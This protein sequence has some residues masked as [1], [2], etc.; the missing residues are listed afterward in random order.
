MTNLTE[1]QSFTGFAYL[2]LEL[3][4]KLSTVFVDKITT[5]HRLKALWD[6]GHKVL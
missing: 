6:F 2:V 3:Y 4:T 1:T 5:Y